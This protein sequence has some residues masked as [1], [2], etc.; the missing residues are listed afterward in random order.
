MKQK[1]KKRYH[2][3][4]GHRQDYTLVKIVKIADAEASAK[5]VEKKV[6]KTETV[7][8]KVEKKPRTKK[9]EA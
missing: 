2:K 9:V 7:E 4:Q 5:K 3:V 8:A 6:E 1:S